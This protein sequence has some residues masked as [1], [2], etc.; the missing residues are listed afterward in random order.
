MNLLYFCGLKRSFRLQ[1]TKPRAKPGTV[2]FGPVFPACDSRPLVLSG[3][4]NFL[5]VGG[6]WVRYQGNPN[7]GFVGR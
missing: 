6:S 2:Y 3:I 7:V 4:P 1:L 5:S